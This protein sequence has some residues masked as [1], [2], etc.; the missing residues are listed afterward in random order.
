MV[1]R[2]KMQIFQFHGLLWLPHN[3]PLWKNSWCAGPDQQPWQTDG[4]VSSIFPKD[5][6]QQ[7]ELLWFLQILLLAGRPWRTER[8]VHPNPV[9]VRPGRLLPRNQGGHIRRQMV[10]IRGS[11]QAH[12][13]RFIM[14]RRPEFRD[15]LK[16]LRQ[17]GK[18]LYVITGG[19]K[20]SFRL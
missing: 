19:E 8:N 6:P 16:M 12:P 1:A 17:N 20:T 15:W 13:E 11:N 7:Q 2:G 3:P 5:H 4:R 14:K 9:C 10:L 18:F